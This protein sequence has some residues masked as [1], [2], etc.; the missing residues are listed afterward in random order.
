MNTHIGLWIDH[1]KAVIVLPSEAGWETREI[2]SNADRHPA[3]NRGKHSTATDGSRSIAAEDVR[4]RR[5]GQHLNAYY[6]EV[7]ACVHGAK[8]LLIFGPGE[9]KGE[10]SVRLS[11]EKPNDR[12]VSVET[13]DKL[14]DRQIIARV[15]DHFKKEN[16]V[17][18]L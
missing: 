14:T 7:I 5:L 17:I 6:D 8:S 13:V 16:P 3:Q 1:R 2:L 10:L 15:R 4:D 11:H 9:A 12:S 18:V